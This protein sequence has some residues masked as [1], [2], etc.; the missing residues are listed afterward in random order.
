MS[1]PKKTIERKK[2]KPVWFGKDRP[3]PTLERVK[4]VDAPEPVPESEWVLRFKRG[5]SKLVRHV[6]NNKKKYIAVGLTGAGALGVPTEYLNQTFNLI[7]TGETME[8]GILELVL[9]IGIPVVGFLVKYL[10]DKKIKKALRNASEFMRAYRDAKKK[11]S[12]QGKELSKEELRS[13][14]D[15]G[16]ELMKSIWG[17]FK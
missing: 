4:E 16:M 15:H 10:K 9:S 17:I 12:D 3:K 11:E 5:A 7:Q 8:F 2:V 14:L 6:L 13:L 1:K